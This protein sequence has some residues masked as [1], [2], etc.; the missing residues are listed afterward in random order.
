MIYEAKV[1]E[2][3]EEFGVHRNTI[4]NWINAGILPAQEGPGRRYL[5]QWEDYRRL[6][7]KY[8]R[9]PR[10]KS[11]AAAPGELPVAP[12][13]PV[14]AASMPVCLDAKAKDLDTSPGLADICL[15][16]GSCA[17]ACPISGVDELDPRKIVRMAFLGLE[18]EVVASSWPWKCTL[19]GKCEAVCPMNVEIVQLL[20]RIRAR[21]DRDK[22]PAAIRKGVVTCL[23][24]GNNLG[25]PKDDFLA[26][27]R[28]MG[29]ELAR[30]S[31][32]GFVTPI[33]VRGTRFLVTV[34]SKQPFAEP[35]A[36]TWWWKIFHAAGE[37]WTISSEYW[38]G[39]NWG[40]HA[41]D[42]GAMRTMVKRIID[43][44]ERLN[45]T[46]LLL[47]ECG[48]AYYATR[49]ALERWFPES[50]QQFKIYS[51]FDLLLEYLNEGR[52]RLDPASQTKL[53]TF[54]DSC[55]YGRHSLKAF[56]HGYFEEARILTKA[57]CKRYVDLVPD[58]EE[59]YCCGAGG[60]AWADPFG[61]E[62]VF[63][64]R[65]KARQISASGAKL[66]VTSCLNCRDQIL[67]SLNREFNL[68]VEV[69]FLWQLVANA[70]VMPPTETR[71]ARRV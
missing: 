12:R 11:D 25:I 17:G 43:N 70:L 10:L 29:E 7:E 26:L 69:Q 27:A 45:C 9:Q 32:P 39:I 19:C 66:V 22:V 55:N 13:S 63:H 50:L 14:A 48:H 67:Y 23:E 40:L 64:G 46:A 62:R 56:G 71:E 49:Y 52:I 41:G 2:L 21:C 33:D 35:E 31:C 5:I 34:N 37:S 28:E 1:N 58:R 60:G 36:M 68:H 15:T 3:A 61:A 30:A 6:C 8:G 65:I 24:R 16:C 20:R 57:C 47:P 59:N 51:V 4:R 54:H 44:I 38:E 42:Y 18:D 53:A